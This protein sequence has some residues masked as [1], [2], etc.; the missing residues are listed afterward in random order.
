MQIRVRM[1]HKSSE[2]KVLCGPVFLNPAAPSTKFKC[3]SVMVCVNMCVLVPSLAWVTCDSSLYTPAEQC[4]NTSCRH[5]TI[6]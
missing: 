2:G 3:Q 5:L 1:G 6:M 4:Q